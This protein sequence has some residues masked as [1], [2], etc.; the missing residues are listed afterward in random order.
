MPNTNS[1]A[2]TAAFWRLPAVCAFLQF[3]RS[4]LLRRVASGEFP[5]PVRLGPNTIAWPAAD[6]RAWAAAKVAERDGRAA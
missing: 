4:T 2:P 5:A 6:V 3:S 1:A